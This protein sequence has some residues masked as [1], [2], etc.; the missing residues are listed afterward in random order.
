ML[1]WNDHWLKNPTGTDPTGIENF[2]FRAIIDQYDCM[3]R[4]IE[5]SECQSMIYVPST[6][7]CYLHGAPTGEIAASDYMVTAW[8]GTN[9][10]TTDPVVQYDEVYKSGGVYKSADVC[11]TEDLTPVDMN[12]K[13]DAELRTTDT[14]TYMTA[15]GYQVDLTGWN[16]IRA[17]TKGYLRHGEGG[18]GK[19]TV[20]GLVPNTDYN[21]EVFSYNKYAGET[22]LTANDNE[23]MTY[24]IDDKEFEKP[25]AEGVVTSDC[26]GRIVF[27]FV[28]GPH[29]N[30][31]H[32]SISG[33]LIARRECSSGSEAAVCKDPNQICKVLDD[34]ASC[35]G[36]NNWEEWNQCSATCGIGT[37][38]RSRTCQGQDCD[39]SADEAE[40]CSMQNCHDSCWVEVFSQMGISSMFSGCTLGYCNIGNGENFINFDLIE[41]LAEY[42]FKLVWNGGEIVK[43]DG[44]DDQDYE[45]EWKQSNNPLSKFNVDMGIYD[46]HLNP[47][48]TFPREFNGLSLS[49]RSKTL[50]DGMGAHEWWW[51]SVGNSGNHFNGQNWG[52]PAYLYQ[53]KEKGK[54]AQK[55]STFRLHST[56]SIN[57]FINMEDRRDILGQWNVWFHS[58]GQER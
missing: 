23:P 43:S 46:A 57:H 44:P 47:S 9:G 8:R 40:N 35:H 11:E 19:A 51:Y 55:N 13:N 50:L 49:S 14:F 34:K 37:R 52:N 16:F 33:L 22:T 30:G 21:F 18:V 58:L 3:D 12:D 17:Y 54:V 27:S 5:N 20:S 42:H 29:D 4:C 26:A 32:T 24:I 38:A 28:S 25:D 48:G 15:N 6:H 10:L 36:W 1:F 53:S 2:K 56:R 45:L 7:K 41:N 39:G 31:P